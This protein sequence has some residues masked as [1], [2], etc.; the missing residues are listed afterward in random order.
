MQL[1][2]K[3]GISMVTY[4]I[5]PDVERCIKC[6]GCIVACKQYN[7]VPTGKGVFRIRI[8]TFNEGE[9][10]E[11]NIPMTCMHCDEPYCL[12]VCPRSAIYKREDGI[13][14]VDKD[15]C[16]GCGYCFY[17][18]PFGAP[19]YEKK[20]VFGS[21]G[22]MDKCTYCVQPYN[23]KNEKGE[24]IEREPMPRCALFCATK[25]LLAGDRNVITKIFH[26][27]AATRNLR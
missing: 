21:K 12:V 17:A 3:K 9:E 2:R 6:G 11:I 16:I 8:V 5:L 14:L 13:V 24:V 23:P 27:R 25:A 22:K 20:G 15:K 26:E 1:K 19:Q 4:K 7:N 10:G 18:C